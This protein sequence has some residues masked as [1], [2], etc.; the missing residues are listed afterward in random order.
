[1]PGGRPVYQQIAAQFR[2]EIEARRLGAGDRLPT[3]RDLARELGVNRD[4]VALAYEA[5]A[6]PG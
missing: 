3:I 4:T 5:L 2:A 6:P 1:M